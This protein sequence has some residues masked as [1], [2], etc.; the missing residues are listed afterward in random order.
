MALFRYRAVNAAGDVAAGELEAANEAEIVDRLRD[1]GL[2]PMKVE[3]ALAGK[4]ASAGGAALRRPRWFESRT[5]TRDQVL[6]VA[7][8]LAALLRAGRPLDRALE[9]PIGLGP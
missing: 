7:G 3:A 1:Q 2:M 4:T 5:V 9:V 8:E 6:G